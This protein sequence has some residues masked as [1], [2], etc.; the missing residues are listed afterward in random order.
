MSNRLSPA[1]VF[2]ALSAALSAGYGV[3][4]TVVGDFRDQYG[5]SET[6]IGVV[7]G[8][9]F[10]AAFVAQVFI[11][12]IADRGRARQLIVA[13]ALANVVGLLM[14]AYGDSLGPILAGRII[15]GIG[16]AANVKVHTDPKT[17]KVKFA[18]AH[19]FRRSFGERWA[20]RV[21]PQVLMELM[22]HESIET[23]LKF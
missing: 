13:G 7:I 2:G 20:P 6:A 4:F 1:W 16:E 21:M 19:D 5:I 8:T 18:S 15:S 11:G 3:L 22:R 12:P 23:T 9:G 14:I 17:G 10:L